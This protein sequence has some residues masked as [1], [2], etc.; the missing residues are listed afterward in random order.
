MCNIAPQAAPEMC[1]YPEPALPPCS[2]HSNPA[3]PRKC[4]GNIPLWLPELHSFL[5]HSCGAG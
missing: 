1:L 5:T 3:F 4:Q 2:S